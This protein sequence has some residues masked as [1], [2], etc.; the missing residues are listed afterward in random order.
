VYT[1]A[2]IR[3]RKEKKINLKLL[4]WLGHFETPD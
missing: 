1:G 4:R 2:K 3:R